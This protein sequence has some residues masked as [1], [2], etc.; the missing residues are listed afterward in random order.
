V[1]RR[2]E[3]AAARILSD[4]GYVIRA[5]DVRLDLG[6]IDIIAEQ[7]GVLVFV[8]VKTRTSDALGG[9]LLGVGPRKRLQLI[10]LAQAYLGDRCDRI[11]WRIDVV[12]LLMDAAGAVVRADIVED[13]TER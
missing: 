7:A 8:E 4:R 2:G 9:P 13:A 10:R 1:G 11:R 12:G 5:V 6:Q 3:E